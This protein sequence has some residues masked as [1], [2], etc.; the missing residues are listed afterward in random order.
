MIV[1]AIYTHRATSDSLL[2]EMAEVGR[3][4]VYKISIYGGEG[5]VP[6]FHFWVDDP[7]AGGCIRLDKPEYFKHGNHVE[8]L[9][10]KS[11]R[12]MIS[13]LQSPHKSLGKYGLTNWQVI[14]IYW[15]DNNIDYP[16]NKDAEMP[17]YKLLKGE[18]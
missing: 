6:H 14:C 3:F 15:D 8:E 1:D 12:R 16:F 4:D 9:N 18:D 5:P 2:L 13:W 11:R 10:S 7:N 17:N